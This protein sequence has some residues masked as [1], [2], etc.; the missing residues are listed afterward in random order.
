M[1]VLSVVDCC[2]AD[3]MAA[4]TPRPGVWCRIFTPLPPT[5]PGSPALGLLG[6]Q[7]DDITGVR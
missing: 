5:E 2:I 1:S 4:E 3:P 7:S 6:Q